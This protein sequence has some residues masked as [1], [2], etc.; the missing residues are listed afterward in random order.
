MVYS[1]GLSTNRGNLIQNILFPK[2]TNFNVFNEVKPI[3]YIML[4]IYLIFA[5]VFIVLYQ[6]ANGSPSQAFFK[7]L[8]LVGT[9]FP[10]TLLICVI[11]TAFYFQYK[12]SLEYIA[13]ISELRL[14]AAGK[15]NNIILDKTGTLTEEGLDLYGFQTTK[16]SYSDTNP[17]SVDNFDDIEFSLD[18][19]NKIYIDFWKRLLNT[20][21]DSQIRAT[22]Q[23][24]YQTNIIYY[25]E[26]LAT[27]HSI[28]KIRGE[29]LGNSIDKSIFDNL[30]W[31]QE[32]FSV[33]ENDEL[34]VNN[35]T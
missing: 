21:E 6:L 29:V 31:N 10:P 9:L 7:I 28:D 15:V 2:S 11:F 23:N 8:T 20:D 26:S 35:I 33:C 19:Y 22:Y 13:C 24:N 12:L 32:I 1:T 27:C 16:I 25:L 14:N 18:L 17:S 3:L 30:E 5:V 34:K 4:F